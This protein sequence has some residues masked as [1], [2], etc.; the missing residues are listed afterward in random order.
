MSFEYEYERYK[1]IVCVCVSTLNGI[2]LSGFLMSMCALPLGILDNSV[3][4]YV[5]AMLLPPPTVS[6]T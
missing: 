4:V 5:Y 2:L 1:T 6:V 3:C